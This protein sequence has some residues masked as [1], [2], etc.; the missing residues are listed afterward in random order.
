[1]ILNMSESS[2]FYT[3]IAVPPKVQD[4]QACIYDLGLVD[5]PHSGPSFTQSN[6][7]AN[8]SLAKKLD[9]VMENSLWFDGFSDYAV[10]FLPPEFSDHCSGLV[11]KK[12]SLPQSPRPFKFFNYLLKHKDFLPAVKETW[13]SSSVFGTRMYQLSR[14]LKSLKPVIRA[15][16]KSD[17]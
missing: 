4:F 7:R 11:S 8:G 1:M 13:A 15:L 14:R 3:G 12:L 6:K 5:L 2:D 9:R 17:Y 10:A 16:S